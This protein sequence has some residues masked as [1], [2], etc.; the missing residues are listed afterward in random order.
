MLSCFS[1]ILAKAKNIIADAIPPTTAITNPHNEPD[2]NPA[3]TEIIKAIAPTKYK[4]E[5]IKPI[6]PI[7]DLS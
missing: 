6:P 7:R 1:K 3:I 4:A 5:I 2:K